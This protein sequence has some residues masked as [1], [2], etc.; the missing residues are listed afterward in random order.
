MDVI[1]IEA[2][3]YYKAVYGTNGSHTQ[4]ERFD[5]SIGLKWL[6]KYKFCIINLDKWNSAKKKHDF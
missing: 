5:T 4:E 2:K 3:S 6:G 1:S